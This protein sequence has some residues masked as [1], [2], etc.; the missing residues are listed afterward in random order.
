M[1]GE[2]RIPRGSAALPASADKAPLRK[3]LLAQRAAIDPN[4]K[5]IWDAQLCAQ[6]VE[7]WRLRPAA[8]APT[9][10]VY[11]PLRGEPDLQAAYA[12]LVQAGAQLA[13]PVVRKR[14]APLD[15]AAWTP[16][17]PMVKDSMG[18]AVP[19]S[20]RLAAMPALMVVPC[21]GF[22]AQGFRLGYGGGFYD[23]TLAAVPRPGTVGVAYACQAARFDSAPHDVP[24]DSMIVA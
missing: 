17:E 1:T 24:L 10:A 11:W 3:A 19:A 9:L 8:L 6:L 5:A 15:F 18:V 7:W 14:D 16:G 13:L 20:L 12:R 22:N 23:R 4:Q 2:P 21:L